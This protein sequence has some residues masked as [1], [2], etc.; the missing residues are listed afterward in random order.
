MRW[1]D[2][3]LK[4]VSDQIR[5]KRIRQP[6]MLE[7]EDHLLLQKDA[8]LDEGLSE[9]EAERRAISDMGDALL[10]GGELDRAHRPQIQWKGIIVALF[11]MALGM[12]FQILFG[13]EGLINGKYLAFSILAAGML[14]LVATVDYTVWMKLTFP[15]LIFWLI[16]WTKRFTDIAFGHFILTMS[17]GIPVLYYFN[18]IINRLLSAL[19]PEC[20]CVA[21]PLLTAFLACRL[22]GQKWGAFAACT[23]IP[24]LTAMLARAY[25]QT[26]YNTNAMMFTALCGFAVMFIAVGRRFFQ[27]SRRTAFVILAALCV[28]PLILFVV[29]LIGY[30][31]YELPEYLT[32]TCEVIAASRLFGHGAEVENLS[33]WIWEYPTPV[34]TLLARIIY[35]FGW[36]PFLLLTA[37]FAGLIVWLIVRFVRMKNRM[38]S[39]LGLSATLTLAVQ[40]VIYYLYS[41]TTYPHLLC[42][43]LIS[44]GNAMLVV[45]SILIGAILSALRGENLPE[46]VR[47][48]TFRPTSA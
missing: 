39:L 23:A 2:E 46:P 8:Y 36:I 26:A 19:I 1:F 45:D 47:I 32:E 35:Q 4:N 38:G 21:A 10:V 11:F 28:L 20:I 5:V 24:V 16:L 43:P 37:A 34:A 14:A 9:T 42:L 3:Y 41:F 33:S 15:A 48:S 22:R 18:T 25:W 44:Y 13:N 40:F 17:S 30:L 7:L 6:L 12:I 31:S 27:V 29:Q